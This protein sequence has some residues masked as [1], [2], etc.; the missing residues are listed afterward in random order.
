EERGQVGDLRAHLLDVGVRRVRVDQPGAHDAADGV[1][2]RLEVFGDRLRVQLA[3]DVP[4]PLCVRR[5]LVELRAESRRD[6]VLL[7][8]L[9][10]R[11]HEDGAGCGARAERHSLQA[12]QATL[13]LVDGRVC[14]VCR[15]VGEPIAECRPS[16]LPATACRRLRVER[17]SRDGVDKLRLHVP[18][19]THGPFYASFTLVTVVCS[20][21]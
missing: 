3:R 13:G 21:P 15:A 18:P 8:R 14:A 19:L 12:G 10:E 16:L 4:V 20:R 2:R 9:P 17:G 7:Q 6:L 11:G 5:R 1:G